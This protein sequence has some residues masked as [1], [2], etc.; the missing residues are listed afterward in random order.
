MNP[1]VISQI[2]LIF[3]LLP[4]KANSPVVTKQH[5]S[6]ETALRGSLSGAKGRKAAIIGSWGHY[7]KK[8]ETGWFNRNVFLMVL[9]V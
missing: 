3:F 9:E 1:F 8:P 5:H 6:R 2:Y 7:N 4:V